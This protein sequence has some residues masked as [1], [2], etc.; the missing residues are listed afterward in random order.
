[1]SLAAV[2]VFADMYV[3]QPLL[4]LLSAEY[5]VSAAVAGTTVSAVVFTIAL[6]SSAYGPLGDALG[7]KKVMAAGCALLAL[8][9]LACGFAPGFT[10][11]VALRAVQGVLVPS[12]SAVAI[13]YL[14]DLRGGEDPGSLVGAYIGA[15]V[16][17]GLVGRV[18]SGLIAQASSWRTPFYVFAAV[19]LLAAAALFFALEEPKAAET[20]NGFA[21]AYREMGAHVGNPRLFGAFLV[22]ATLF[23]GFIGIF[24]YLPYLLSAPPFSLSTGTIAWFYAAYLAG[25]FTAPLAGRL[26]GRYSRRVLIAAGF[27]VALCGIALTALGALTAIAAGTIVLCIGMFAAQAIA[28]AYVNVTATT[29]KGG[30]NALYTTFYYVGAVLGSTLPGL[31]LERFG[32]SGVVWTCAASLVVGLVADLTLCTGDGPTPPAL[33]RPIRD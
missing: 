1:M 15:T 28:P 27:V 26:S 11:L 13:A 10:A 4:P 6:A 20:H 19:T 12:V 24:T 29:A 17:G 8:A 32:W 16:F 22:A 14:G 7:R 5:G 3:T 30:A 25:V 2:A 31:A 33:P 23:F 18:G 9:T 21:A